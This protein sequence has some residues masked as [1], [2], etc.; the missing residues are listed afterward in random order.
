[1]PPRSLIDSSPSSVMRWSDEQSTT[2][3]STV[4]NKSS[5]KSK[6]RGKGP[7][8]IKFVEERNKVYPITHLDDIPEEEVNA[9][10]YDGNEYAEIKQSYQ[11][12]IFMMEAG[13]QLNLEEHTS[14]GLEYRTQEGAWARYENKRD[15]YN[16]VLD[17]QDRQWQEDQDDDE[18]I[19][20]I[21]LEHSSKC[22]KAAADRA[23]ADE[24]EALIILES[25]MPKNF[26]KNQLKKKEKDKVEV[27]D[28]EKKKKK[29]S[30]TKGAAD[31][32]QAREMLRERSTIR[33]NEIQD[34]IQRLEKSKSGSPAVN[35]TGQVSV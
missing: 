8:G 27:V 29:K 11:L 17:E 16:A 34:D 4:V 35:R 21:Y 12:T 23:K 6:K 13:E 30:T 33:R 1:M 3:S 31:I 9:T 24:A 32:A 28:G 20:I 10:W 22:A 25:I 5:S 2:S 26:R 14:R 18:K 7:K 19:S 15:A